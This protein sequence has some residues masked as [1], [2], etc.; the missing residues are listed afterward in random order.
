MTFAL[1]SIESFETLGMIENFWVPCFWH[2]FS[3]VHQYAII[4]K[5]RIFKGLK[6]VSIKSS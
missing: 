4:T 1:K 3:K 5:E 2:A 6:Y